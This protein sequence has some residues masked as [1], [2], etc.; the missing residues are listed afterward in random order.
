LPIAFE[1]EVKTSQPQDALENGYV[2]INI[3]GRPIKGKFE[4]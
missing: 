2:Q 1:G 4:L 3:E